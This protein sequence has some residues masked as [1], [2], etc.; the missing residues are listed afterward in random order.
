MRRRYI[1]VPH[2]W[3]PGHGAPGADYI[4]EVKLGPVTY[5]GVGETKKEALADAVRMAKKKH[6]RSASRGR[7]VHKN[8]IPWAVVEA[9]LLASPYIYEAG[10]HGVKE[11]K[12]LRAALK[13]RRR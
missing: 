8:P 11:F 13:K 3:P 4:A 12:K 6:P 10:R 2:S 5:R 1:A 9:G 7:K